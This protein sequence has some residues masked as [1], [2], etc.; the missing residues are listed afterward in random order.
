MLTATYPADEFT[1]INMGVSGNTLRDLSARWQT[2][3][4]NLQ[5]DW[6]SVMIGIN[7]VW[8]QFD[9]PGLPSVS[10]VEEYTLI[11]EQLL[12][13]TAPIVS[14]IV[15]MTPFFIEENRLDPMRKMTEDYVEAVRQIARKH[16]V[17]LVDTQTIFD[18]MLAHR[19]FQDLSGDHVHPTMTGHMILARAFLQALGYVW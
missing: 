8:P 10:S 6:L 4:L 3:V 5:P 9:S 1:V 16:Q 14:G 7:D 15:L 18:T 12:Q 11:L 17:I 2:D 13:Q 19:P